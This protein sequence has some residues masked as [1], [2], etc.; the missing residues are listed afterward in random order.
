MIRTEIGK[1]RYPLA[2]SALHRI[3]ALTSLS[4]VL[5]HPQEEVP[6]PIRYCNINLIELKLR[7][8]WSA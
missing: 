2:W 7:P 1:S 6:Q 3:L 8:L 4:A 5:K